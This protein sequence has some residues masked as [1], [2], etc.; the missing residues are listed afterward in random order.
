MSDLKHRRLNG[1]VVLR[2]YVIGGSY[3]LAE[4]HFEI[5]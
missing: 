1:L 5:W 2:L 4:L 3:E